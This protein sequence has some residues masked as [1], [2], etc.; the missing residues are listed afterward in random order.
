MP[1][2]PRAP[3]HDHVLDFHGDLRVDPYFWLRERSEDIPLLCD[4]FLEKFRTRYQKN[5]KT[6]A[7]A[8]Y[9]LL[10]RNRWPGNVRELENA[11][12]RAVVVGKGRQIMPE[13]M[14]ISC[15]KPEAGPR[16]AYVADDRG[17]RE[18]QSWR[19]WPWAVSTRL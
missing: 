5:V 7:P 14:P 12:E 13:D 16:R 11:I 8:V 19:W 4:H 9:H 17:Q 3:R 6:L 15:R 1:T 10:I 2:P 18:P